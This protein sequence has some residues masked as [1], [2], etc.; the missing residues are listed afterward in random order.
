VKFAQQ[1]EATMPMLARLSL[2]IRE[3]PNTQEEAAADKPPSEPEVT[4]ALPAVPEQGAT[5]EPEHSSPIE[6]ARPEPATTAPAK[7]EASVA[8]NDRPPSEA[9]AASPRDAS[10]R[11]SAAAEEPKDEPRQEGREFQVA[12]IASIDPQP[13]GDPP[14]ASAPEQNAVD[15]AAQADAAAA[16]LASTKIATLGGPPV[17]IV[18][19]TKTGG[20]AKPDDSAAKK[21]EEERRAAKRR[22][23]AAARARLAA[24]QGLQ[25]LQAGPFLPQPARAVRAR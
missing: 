9:A 17:D 8:C 12:A 25:P 5:V 3:E 2:E 19:P 20:E 15:I 6:A 11:N 21:L 7:P 18:S 14:L 24:Q 13:R 23:I 1:G 22:R 4:G 16:N 10:P